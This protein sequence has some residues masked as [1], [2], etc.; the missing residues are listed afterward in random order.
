MSTRRDWLSLRDAV[1]PHPFPGFSMTPVHLRPDGRGTVRLNSADPFEPPAVLFD[2]LR[3]DYD[4]QA[5]LFGVE[6]QDF[7][8]DDGLGEILGT[9]A[10]LSPAVRGRGAG[11]ERDTGER[12]IGENE[13]FEIRR[14]RIDSAAEIKDFLAAILGRS[15]N[16]DVNR[17]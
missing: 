7:G 16:H 17:F 13:H 10:Q 9:D 8:K 14:N 15:G 11:Q 5:M 4:M 1:I 2:Y 3:T 12:V 6:P